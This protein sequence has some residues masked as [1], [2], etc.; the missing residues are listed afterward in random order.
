MAA[1]TPP[2]FPGVALQART[3]TTWI[4][5][6]RVQRCFSCNTQFSML[7]RKHHCRSCGRIFCSSC[8]AYRETIPSYY[9]SYA[10]S[11]SQSIE[12][13][14]TCAPCA[15]NL[16]RA[17]EVEWLVRALAVMPIP[18]Y[19][20]FDVRLV[21]RAWNHAVNTLLSLYQGLQ[22]RLP[23][24][25]YTRVECDFLWSHY[26]EFG[27]HI[28]WQIH[29][30]ACLKSF[31]LLEHRLHIL[32]LAPNK[33]VPCRWLLCSK[34]C[35]PSMSVDNI[36]HVAMS[37]CLEYDVF[38]KW[39][40]DSWKFFQPIVHIK[41]MSWWV[42]IGLKY[43]KLFKHGLVPLCVGHIDLMYALWFECLLQGNSRNRRF[44]DKIR[45]KILEAVSETIQ[46]DVSAS[47][48]FINLLKRLV[49]VTNSNAHEEMIQNFFKEHPDVRAP[50]SPCERIRN[51][52]DTKRFTSKT[53]PLRVRCEMIDGCVLD[54]LIKNEDVRTDR[55]AMTIGYWIESLTEHIHVHRYTVFPF[56][57]SSGC[58]VMIPNAMTL[59]DIR[60]RTTL[61]NHVLSCNPNMLVFGLRENI[62]SS[63]VGACLLA[64]TM[65]LGD[66]HLENIMVTR[67]GYLAHVDFGYVLGEDPKHIA[68]PMR[69][70]EDMVE[71][72]GGRSSTSFAAFVKRTQVGY[73][74][75]RSYASF[76]YHLLAAEFYI[77][78][79]KS[80]HWKRIRDHVLDRFVPGELDEEAS[81][82][83]QTVVQ[84]ATNDSVVQ[85]MAD[86]AHLASNQ[87]V[88]GIFHIEL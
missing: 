59:Y 66:R 20:L 71:A 64:F 60:R 87:L 7:R 86:F 5:D 45:S 39:V 81:L 14:R 56:D 29:T 32:S 82:H 63:C 50:W 21:S 80:R 28:P 84:R 72:I 88:G 4:P 58:V 24:Q 55:L 37:G 10:P 38:I 17:S 73:E 83:I 62:V 61:L 6:S 46:Y 18:F 47:M 30:F 40:I 48:A 77:F 34:A 44:L 35:R 75:M 22:Y 57:D 15:N 74:H 51:I 36:I 43:P 65:G 19:K 27:G 33:I 70:T 31:E 11:P 68:T 78:G 52:V 49:A 23:C 53:R 1:M 42:Y 3:P 76:W 9:R 25:E 8:S 54:V 69:I 79:D 41:M 85:R 12:P 2:I 16:R 13:Q 26:N 67:E